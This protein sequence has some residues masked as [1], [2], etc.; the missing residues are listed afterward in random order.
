MNFNNRKDFVY[1]T[2]A[3]FFVTNA[4]IGELIGG[5]LIQMGPFAMSMGVLPWPIVL[6]VTDL[7]NEHFG[8]EG[9]KKLTYLTMGLI[10]YAFVILFAAMQVPAAGFSPVKDEMFNGVFGQSLWIIVGS[11]IAFA[12]SQLLDVTVFTYIKSKTKNRFLWLRTAGSTAISQM[13]DSFAI[14]G[15]AFWL[16][17]AIKTNEFLNVAATNYSYKFIMAIGTIPLIYIAH[18]AINSILNKDKTN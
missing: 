7:I 2:L 11:I 9:V 16:P 4:I 1:L 14:V 15:I 8:K 13:F 12:G 18:F 6:I 17:G 10:A 5:K 3:G